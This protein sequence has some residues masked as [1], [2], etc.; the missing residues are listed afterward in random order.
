MFKDMCRFPS[1]I[2]NISEGSHLQGRGKINHL[3]E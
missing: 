3:E 2:V 1:T